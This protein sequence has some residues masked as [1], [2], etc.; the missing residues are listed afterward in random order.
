MYIG[1]SHRLHCNFTSYCN[2]LQHC[3]VLYDVLLGLRANSRHWERLGLA[4][5]GL[6]KAGAI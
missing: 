3:H 1:C 2:G 6:P 4:K 5:S